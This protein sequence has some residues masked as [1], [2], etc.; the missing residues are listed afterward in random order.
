MSARISVIIPYYG[1]DPSQLLTCLRSL[2]IQSIGSNL[3]E[4]L[5]VDNNPQPVLS[6]QPGI[7]L[8]HE[9][10]PGAYSARNAGIRRAS[11][12]I[13]AF[14]DSDCVPARDWAFELLKC[15][16]RDPG[17]AVVA[18]AIQPTFRNPKHI[19]VVEAYDSCVHMRQQEYAE[20][21]HFGATAN[22]IVRRSIFQ[23]VELFDER[24]FSGGDREWGER[25][26]QLEYR[27]QYHAQVIVFHSAR[28]TL[29]AV[30]TKARRLVGR[31]IFYARLNKTPISAVLCA[32]LRFACRRL[33][34]VWHRR[35]DFN[36][37]TLCGMS[38]VVLIVFAVRGGHVWATR[39][40]GKLHR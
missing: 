38:M 30:F 20:R 2:A 36:L 18:G 1:V 24:L 3:L 40:G 21:F 7:V 9:P 10:K 33:R 34:L 19:S 5:I 4:V 25:A 22:L 35:R 16:D 31:E 14:I 17:C 12:D 23:K 15:F 27:V 37:A 11:A 29:S 32:E 13:L 6:P 8:L 26:W 39:R 28:H